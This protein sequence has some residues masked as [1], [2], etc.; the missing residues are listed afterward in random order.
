MGV[1]PADQSCGI[2]ASQSGF[3]TY[4]NQGGK[5]DF[6]A[7]SCFSAVKVNIFC[8]IVLFPIFAFPLYALPILYPVYDT[9]L[10]SFLIILAIVLLSILVVLIFGIV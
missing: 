3:F 9:Y 8:A 1:I 2:L 7:T 6:T 4:K 5:G 10:I